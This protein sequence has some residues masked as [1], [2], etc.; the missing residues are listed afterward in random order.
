MTRGIEIEPTATIRPLA[1]IAVALAPALLG[2]EPPL[3]PTPLPP[4]VGR[5]AALHLGA[6]P[7]AFTPGEVMTWDVR[8]RGLA[9]GRATLQVA[10][11]PGHLEV[12]SR[13]RTRGLAARLR[14]LV[15]HLVT[16]LPGRRADDLHAAL[17]R[18]RSWAAR[19]AAPATG[20]VRFRGR[21]YRLDLAAPAPATAHLGTER[22]PA[23]RIDGEARGGEVRMALS[24][25]LS[26]D[27]LR[28]PLAIELERR[29]QRVRAELSSYRGAALPRRNTVV[30]AAHP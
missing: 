14:P 10:G 26:A 2:C 23:I 27:G 1:A 11:A 3:A 22:R 28:V 8:W 29:G 17:G 20:T 16:A 18:V 21:R 7:I 5:R 30:P 15:H 24:L 19:G 6:Q 4:L 25:W 13:F 9:V 12:E